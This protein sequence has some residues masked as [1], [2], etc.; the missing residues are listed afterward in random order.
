MA[1]ENAEWASNFG[2]P[3]ATVAGG[4]NM[5]SAECDPYLTT[6]MFALSIIYNATD[7]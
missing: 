1:S 6:Q 7:L 2:K 4:Q 3:L 5:S